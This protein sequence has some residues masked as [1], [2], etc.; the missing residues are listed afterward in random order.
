MAITSV[1]GSEGSIN[2]AATD[3]GGERGGVRGEG[4]RGGVRGEGERG[5]VEH[6]H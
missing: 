3:R 4:E 1:P 5:C 2:G 6:V